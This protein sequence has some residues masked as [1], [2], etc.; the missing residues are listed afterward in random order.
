MAIEYKDLS[1]GYP[2]TSLISSATNYAI[3][4]IESIDKKYK[5]NSLT[6]NDTYTNSN[7]LYLFLVGETSNKILWFSNPLTK[8]TTGSV[9]VNIGQYF[10]ENYR[11]GLFVSSGSVGNINIPSKK[12]VRVNG[13]TT[14]SKVGDVVTLSV[15]Y[16]NSSLGFLLELEFDIN[17]ILIQLSNGEIKSV[18]EEK[19]SNDLIPP[20]TSNTSESITV[21]ASSIYSTSWDVWKAF[22]GNLLGYSWMANTTGGNQWIKI[23]FGVNNEKTIS[24]INI[25]PRENSTEMS[26][27]TFNIEG[28]NDNSTWTVIHSVVDYTNWI[29]GHFSTF[30][31]N[32][33]NSYRYYRINI[34]SLVDNTKN[35]CIGE[36]E[37]YERISNKLVK[38]IPSQTEQDFINHGMDK[39]TVLDLSQTMFKKSFVEKNTTTLG[40]GKVFSKPIDT[41]QLLIKKLTIK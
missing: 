28:S 29:S 30:I 23:D 25:A 17:K 37:L 13:V 15:E 22:D 36:I 3:M 11:I 8:T 10:S 21:S 19:Y 6:L 5:I 18:E 27:S 16:V 12:T 14:S 32:N 2:T 4:T 9:T 41:T 38:L 24:K 33:Q 34:I 40:S 7:S 31:F 35:A 20:M 39:S 1:Y 26:P